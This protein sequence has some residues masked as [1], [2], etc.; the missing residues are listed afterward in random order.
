MNAI[1]HLSP[2]LV[3]AI[4]CMSSTGS[5]TCAHGVQ[6]ATPDIH[7]VWSSQESQT[8]ASLRGL[9][10]VN[11]RVAWASG[12][13]GTVVR[14]IDGGEHWTRVDV[15]H[16]D[17]LDFRDIH[18]FDEQTCVVVN[19]GSPAFIFRTQD[20]G[21]TWSES[22]RNES[23][24]IF[25]DALSFW[26]RDRGIAFSDPQDGRLFVIET[27]DGGRTWTPIDADRCP[28]THP[29]EAAFAAS[30]TSMAA[31]DDQL[32]WIATGG[33][34]GPDEEASARVFRTEDGGR[35]WTTATTP[36]FSGESAGIFSIAFANAD[37]G[38]VVGGDYK[39]PSSSKSNLAI[40]DDSGL[41]WR[42][43]TGSLG[44]YRSAVAVLNLD[45]HAYLVAVGPTGTDVSRDWGDTWRTID[46]SSFNSVAF[47]GDGVSGW[48]VGEKGR[49]ARWTGNEVIRGD[50]GH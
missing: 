45:F 16:P 26:D 24:T 8:E 34:H 38:V 46:E 18:A 49:I 17:R 29:G 11:D 36:V 48:A 10:V 14:T 3:V 23:K 31:M 42:A 5:W 28:A 22:Y 19:A 6:D 12:T 13:Q 7:S 15:P 50:A 33:E 43:P 37:H 35:N 32:A 39:V 9:S 21:K 47:S 20:G 2:L 25:F 27:A 1:R 4:V 44:G 40:S 41:H 30:G